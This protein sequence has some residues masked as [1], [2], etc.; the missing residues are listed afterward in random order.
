M[1]SWGYST[2]IV[3]STL[4]VVFAKYREKSGKIGK[5]EEKLGRKGKNRKGSLTLP[6]LT[7]RAGYATV[8][9]AIRL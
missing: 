1:P 8:R 7:E 5:K 2:R 6:L 9:E 4:R 3:R